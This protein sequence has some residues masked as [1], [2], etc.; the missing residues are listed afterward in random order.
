MNNYISIKEIMDDLLDNP[1]LQD[2]TLERTVYYTVQFIR[3]VGMPRVYQEKIEELQIEEYRA[4]LPCDFYKII[5][6]R[7][8]RTK[9]I[10]RTSTDNFHYSKH[11]ENETEYTYKIQ[12]KV[13]Y[14]T[15]KDNIVE[16]SYQ[17]IPVD[18]DGYP[19]VYDDASF[20]E[21]LE[22]YI[23]K[24]RYK[25]LYDNGN[26]RND[27]Y[28]NACQEYAFLVGQ[29]QNSLIMPTIDEMQSITNMW[30]TLITRVSS[31]DSGFKYNGSKETL[32]NQ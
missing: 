1:L 14:T 16:L 2:L 19:M 27:V 18:C 24:K 23:T 26:I 29:A 7:D 30:N 22:A 17:A 6:L 25:L 31:H 15:T 20:I 9:Q 28:S 11:N 8:K 5:Q 21:A 10:Y 4:L 3:K 13:L 32:Y 12:N